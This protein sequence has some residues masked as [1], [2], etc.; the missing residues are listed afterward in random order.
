MGPYPVLILIGEPN[1]PTSLEIGSLTPVQPNQVNYM[2][3]LNGGELGTPGVEITITAPAASVMAPAITVT[4]AYEPGVRAGSRSEEDRYNLISLDALWLG[5]SGGAGHMYDH[6]P[7]V[8]GNSML[9]VKK[10][11]LR[12][13]VTTHGFVSSDPTALRQLRQRFSA[14]GNRH[15]QLLAML[16]SPDFTGKLYFRVPSMP[17]I[18]MFNDDVLSH[19]QRACH[20]RLTPYHQ[21]NNP[22]NVVHLDMDE[23]PGFRRHMMCD[24]TIQGTVPTYSAPHKVISDTIGRHDL[25]VVTMIHGVGICREEQAHDMYCVGLENASIII[26]LVRTRVPVLS[27]PRRDT[28][29]NNIYGRAAEP[30]DQ[31]V[32]MGFC[33]IVSGSPPA[34][35]RIPR[36]GSLGYVSWVRWNG[37]RWAVTEEQAF[38]MVLAP[39]AR[40][41]TMQADFV[42]ALNIRDNVIKQRASQNP[43]AERVIFKYIRN[44][45]AGQTQLTGI[46]R[47][48][49]STIMNPVLTN[50]RTLMIHQDVQSVSFRDLSA[51]PEEQ[52]PPA[53]CATAKAWFATSLLMPHCT[54]QEIDVLNLATGINRYMH[55]IRIPT[56]GKPARSVYALMGTLMLVG[57][58]FV[59][60][61]DEPA[62][63]SEFVHY[64]HLFLRA[65]QADPMW[66]NRPNLQSKRIVSCSI[67]DVDVTPVGDDRS[68]DLSSSAHPLRRKLGLV[69]KLMLGGLAEEAVLYDTGAYHGSSANNPPPNCTPQAWSMADRV[70]DYLLRTPALRAQYYADRARVLDP[71]SISEADLTAI[72]ERFKVVHRAVF[73]EQDVVVCNYNTAM[74][75]EIVKSFEKHIV[76]CGNTHRIPF[77]KVA[78]VIVPH[79]SLKAAILLG[80]PA[81]RRFG[82]MQL[83]SRGRNEA[84]TTFGRSAWDVLEICGG[85][86]CTNVMA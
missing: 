15:G 47:L 20:F 12:V 86:L 58:R 73:A 36:P 80:H 71:G 27:R 21:Y 75:E 29:A 50:L 24:R 55:R 62:A 61:I 32:Y 49:G 57:Y 76:I 41:T 59:V 8:V 85:S 64:L 67:V 37:Q 68:T 45:Q 69:F 46:K 13:Q 19:L 5:R 1:L 22:A 30:V 82:P 53:T 51:G 11:T 84:L 38:G 10:R 2:I 33:K 6:D 35:I 26:K 70:S 31:H 43:V 74:G 18:Q 60:A 52:H 16:T 40:H 14:A 72:E 78:A 54:L 83:A 56:G 7:N 81:D 9:D 34:P 42:M 28:L 63:R 17:S 79:S 44:R 48:G 4:L 25:R 39:H 3:R 23:L 65:V 66:L 77:S